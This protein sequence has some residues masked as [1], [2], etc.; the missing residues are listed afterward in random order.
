M[1]GPSTTGDAEHPHFSDIIV[2]LGQGEETRLYVGEVVR[3]FGDRGL[4]AV[5][6]LWSL[7]NFLPLPPGGT[8][9][10]GF[11]LLIL[12]M[13][14]ALGRETLWLPRKVMASSISRQTFRRSFGWLVPLI[15]LAERLSRP[16]LSWL[17]GQFSQSLA[18][19][20]C[21]LLSIVLVLPIP[22][23]NIVPAITM[24][25]LSLG[26]MQRD[27]VAVILGW[28]SAAISIGLLALAW[29]IVAR[30]VEGLLDRLAG[31]PLVLP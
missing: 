3:A 27:G 31:L 18:G 2:R 9:I 13:E 10:T 12:S 21:F 20:V 4:A 8:T 25:L 16:R 23:G 29:K 14:L 15:R 22:L 28:I 19:L 1:N 11:P 6:L 17:V 7:V 24:A 5:M 30:M 26:V